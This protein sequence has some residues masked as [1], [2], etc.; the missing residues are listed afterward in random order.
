LI[1]LAI[2]ITDGLDVAHQKGIIHR[3]N[4]DGEHFSNESG[5]SQDLINMGRGDFQGAVAGAKD[6]QLTQVHAERE[7]GSRRAKE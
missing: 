3:D 5:R 2:Q 6:G 7:R 4:Q 1:D